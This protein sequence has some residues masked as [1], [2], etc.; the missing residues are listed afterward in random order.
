MCYFKIKP[1]KLFK[2]NVFN[3]HTREINFKVY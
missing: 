1:Y 3:H 2:W